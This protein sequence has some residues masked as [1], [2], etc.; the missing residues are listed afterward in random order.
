MVLEGAPGQGKSTLAQYL[1]QVHRSRILQE[2]GELAS[3]PP[4]HRPYA[5]RLP[6]K[7]DLRDLARW[8]DKRNPFS[9]DDDNDEPAGWAPSLDAFLAAQV[10]YYSGGAEFAVADLHAVARR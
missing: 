5:I 9:P 8:F 7:V 6:F 3:L 2:K 1:C 10:R 4:E